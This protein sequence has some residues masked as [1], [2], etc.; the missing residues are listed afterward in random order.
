MTK[1]TNLSASHAAAFH[2]LAGSFLTAE[3][4]TSARNPG[5]VGRYGGSSALYRSVRGL[6]LEIVFEPNDGGVAWMSCGREWSLKGQFLCLSSSYWR[7]AQRSGFELPREYPI[8]AEESQDAVA[9]RIVADLK[10]SLPVI[11]SR[12]SLSD[13]VAVESEEPHGAAAMALRSFGANYSAEVQISDF[14]GN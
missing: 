14:A 4:F 2:S 3:G 11:V 6:S 13:L 5:I 7:L 1:T 12:V 8:G 10:R 9:E